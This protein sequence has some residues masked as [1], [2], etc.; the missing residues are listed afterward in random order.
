MSARDESKQCEIGMEHRTRQAG[1]E[2]WEVQILRAQVSQ[3]KS[4]EN[5]VQAL[6]GEIRDH[7]R[8]HGVAES[9]IELMEREHHHEGNRIK[10]MSQ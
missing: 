9:A 6:L 7:R 5:S 8:S 2:A 10:G 1:Q 3:L 4:E